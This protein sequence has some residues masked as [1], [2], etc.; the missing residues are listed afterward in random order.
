[1]DDRRDCAGNARRSNHDLSK[2][3]E[4]AWRMAGRDSTHVP[5]HCT[6]GIKVGRSNLQDA[7]RSVFSSDRRQ[8]FRRDV[9]RDE[10]L[11]RPA[12][13]HAI[14]REAR[15]TVARMKN[16]LRTDRGRDVPNDVV[17]L[18]PEK[19]KRGD[20]GACAD[21]RDDLELRS[22]CRGHFRL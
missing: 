5:R 3:L 14:A 11:Q 16:V 17:V 20:Q 1:M 6:P 19:G 2:E 13:R 12:V 18:R 8:D 21:A 4:R 22:D 9:L 15:E 10:S 7:P